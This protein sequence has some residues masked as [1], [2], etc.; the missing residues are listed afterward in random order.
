[1]TKAVPGKNSAE[2]Q[3]VY[4]QLNYQ[5]QQTNQRYNQAIARR[6]ILRKEID[7]LRMELDIFQGV[8]RNINRS[9]SMEEKENREA[10]EALD[11]IT[12][13]RLDKE[14]QLFKMKQTVFYEKK[15]FDKNNHDI[16]KILDLDNNALTKDPETGRGSTQFARVSARSNNPERGEPASPGLSDVSFQTKK[17]R[18]RARR[19]QTS[20]KSLEDIEREVNNIEHELFYS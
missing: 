17:K 8:G 19:T 1:M 20:E 9:M 12:R 13:E 5:L 4:K 15:A 16:L 3:R 10:Q 11:R 18:Q 2:L 6:K 14:R 7:A